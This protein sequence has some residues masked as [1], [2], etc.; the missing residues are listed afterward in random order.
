MRHPRAARPRRFTSHA[1]AACAAAAALAVPAP[2]RA[3][4]E[5]PL[6]KLT[7]P[8]VWADLKADA[9]KGRPARMAWADDRATLYL[10]TVEGDTRE[11]LVYHHYLLRQGEKLK[12]VD[13]QPPWADSYWKWKSAK[14]LD[15]DPLMSISVDTHK[16]VVDNLNGIAANKGVYLTDSPIGVTGQALMLAKQSGDSV[17]VSRLELKGQVIGEFVNE[18]IVPG[19]TFSWSPADMRLIA[20]R[21]S[22]GRL[23]IM[24]DEGQLEPVADTKDV[25]LPAWSDDGAALAYLERAKGRLVVHVVEIE[26]R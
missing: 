10:Q 1:L 24:N 25:L 14:S 5:R 4:P 17:L 18:L 21:A 9:L 19:Y 15:G 22:S 12:R 20:F 26:G 3:E 8:A 7:A 2:A 11:T 13:A 6:V 16:E 23:T